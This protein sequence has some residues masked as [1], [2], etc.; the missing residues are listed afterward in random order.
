SHIDRLLG[1]PNVDSTESPGYHMFYLALNMRRPPLD[2]LVIRRAIAHA[3]DRDEIILSL[4]QGCMLPLAEFV[5]PAS[6]FFNP[7][8]DVAYYDPELAKQILDDA[9]YIVGPNGVRIDPA[10]GQELRR[11]TIMTPTM[12]VAATSAM[13]GEMVAETLRGIGLPVYAEPIDF[14][15]LLDRL[16]TDVDGDRDFDMYALAWS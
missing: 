10:T 1:D 13:L 8:T 4:F 15:V 2:D 6:P 7:D 14:T 3:I 16:D 5:P 12:E 9:G 11:M